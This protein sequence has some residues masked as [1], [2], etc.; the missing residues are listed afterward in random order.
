MDY[1]IKDVW[2]DITGAQAT[3][4][5]LVSDGEN[6]WDEFPGG[7]S[8]ASLSCSKQY[9]DGG[10]YLV[11]YGEFTPL[12]TIWIQSKDVAV[13]GGTN[14]SAHLAE[15]YQFYSRPD[16]SGAGDNH[17]TWRCRCDY[18]AKTQERK[19]EFKPGGYE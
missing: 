14:G 10:A 8:I 1:F 17:L 16:Y 12:K 15:F 2:M 11:D 5:G 19:R 9:G 7:D 18:A 13:T 4:T 6:V 3:G